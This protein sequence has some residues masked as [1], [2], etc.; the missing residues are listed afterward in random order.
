MRQIFK[1]VLSAF[2]FLLMV[3]TA[4]AGKHTDYVNPFIGT[5][6][7]D[8]LL[9]N[10]FPGAS[11][12]FGMVQLSPDTKREPSWDCASGYCYNDNHIYGFS[13]TR[14]S[15]TG[16]SD[17]ID[18][19]TMPLVDDSSLS[20]QASFSHDDESAHPGYYQ[21]RLADSGINAEL[22]ATAHMGIHRYIY[23][24]DSPQY[25]LLDLDHSAKKGDW[26]RRI[27]NAQI[28]QVSQ[29]VIEGYRVITGWAKMRRVYFRIELSRPMTS[30]R[31]Y[32]DDRAVPGA[33]VVNGENVKAMLAFDGTTDSEVLMKVALSAVSMQ[34]AECNMLAEDKGWDFNAYR[35]FSDL[36]WEKMLSV[37]D[38]EG[39]TDDMVKFYTALYHTML[40]PNV[41]S[42][43]DGTYIAS[44][45]SEKKMPEGK[46]Y[47]STLSLWDTYRAAHPLYSILFPKLNADFIESMLLH[48]ENYGYL[49][50]WSLWGQ[51]N[52]CM[53]GNHAIPV[54][55]DA[56]MNGSWKG[57]KERAYQAVRNSS[58][59]NHTNSPFDIWEQ[60]GYMPEDKQSQSVSITLEMSFDDWCVARLAESLGHSDDA[61]RFYK[62]SRYYKSL[63]NPTYGF[64]QGKTSDG[65]W[66][67]PFNPLQYGA[68]GG[69]PYTEGNGWQWKWYVPHDIEGMIALFGGRNA[70]E[71]QLDIFFA[72]TE[73]FGEKNSNA[74]GFI[75]QYVHGNEPDHHVPFLYNYVGRPRK[76]QKI[77]RQI[78][79][80]LYRNAPSGIAGNDDC[81]E[82]SAWYVL[83]SLGFYPVNPASGRYAVVTPLFRNAIIRLEDDRIF[84]ITSK[85]GDKDKIYIGSM[86]LNGKAFK[87][88][89]LDYR[90][91][92]A[93]GV[94]EVGCIK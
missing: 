68:N 52:Y 41:M 24:K 57:D 2:S 54:I 81:G 20:P 60:Y 61:V 83:T 51:E 84:T 50:I 87:G 23:P 40:Q 1:I 74:S 38:V 80:E 70:M 15:G 66:M 75:G 65:K 11:V 58:L 13:H 59:R 76:T 89:E 22:S 36:Q 33:E 49:P 18:I 69:S 79:D 86:R 14:L 34:G 93:G 3:M 64:F 42:D 10:T 43:C 31:L 91:I 45:Y 6:G 29:N 32:K 37:V 35:S 90:D 48:Y 5:D 78:I 28:R 46:S 12:P 82:L 73:Q 21:V 7:Q 62:R 94:F 53:I 88:Y 63:Y 92:I 30:C 55:V 8:G 25:I 4:S 67:E 47:Y 77:V 26:N 19:L 27:I 16:V 72:T 39:D 17:L 44:D 85:N 9:G 71:D 56:V